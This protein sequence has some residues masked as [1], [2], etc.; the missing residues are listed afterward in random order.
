MMFSS[1][2]EGTVMKEQ[3]WRNKED[4][5]LYSLLGSLKEAGDLFTFNKH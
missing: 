1:N 3:L 5:K 2:A 4:E